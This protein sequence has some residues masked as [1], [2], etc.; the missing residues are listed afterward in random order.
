M[1]FAYCCFC[2]CCQSISLYLGW[3]KMTIFPCHLCLVIYKSKMKSFYNV[4]STKDQF[5]SD[6]GK[7][8]KNIMT[9]EYS[10]CLYLKYICITFKMTSWEMSNSQI[11]QN[12][13]HYNLKHG[14]LCNFVIILKSK[15]EC[16]HY[17]WITLLIA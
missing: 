7:C 15:V 6:T 1:H 10:N 8:W 2:F 3:V 5:F 16:R 4:I 13:M 12:Y 17:W 11:T 14:I 9:N